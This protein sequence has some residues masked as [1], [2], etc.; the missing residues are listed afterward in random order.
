MHRKRPEHVSVDLRVHLTAREQPQPMCFVHPA[1]ADGCPSG[2]AKVGTST[3]PERGHDSSDEGGS[4]RESVSGQQHKRAD[5]RTPGKRGRSR[6]TRQRRV[7][8]RAAGENP[9][10]HRLIPLH[11]HEITSGLHR[12]CGFT[13]ACRM[14]VRQLTQF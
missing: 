11:C 10:L 6:T 12:P 3:F 1:G 9:A 13:S 4:C 2:L 14:A 7:L 5:Y 8:I